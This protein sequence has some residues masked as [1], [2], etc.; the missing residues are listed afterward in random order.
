[1]TFRLVTWNI[2]S[3]R[4]RLHLLAQ[5]AEALDPDVI[6]LQEIKVEDAKFPGEAIAEIGYPHQA[7]FGMKAYHGVATLAKAPMGR[8]TRHSWCGKDDARHV[9]STVAGGVELHNLY[10]PAGG[11]VPDP[12]ANDKFAHKLNFFDEQTDWWAKQKGRAKRILVGDLNVAPL[13]TDVWNHKQL[14]KV[15]SHTPIEVEHYSRMEAA[16]KWIDA[17]RH[18]IPPEEHLYSWWSYRARDWRASNKGRRLDH[19]WVTPN[20]K[21]AIRD[22]FVYD[23]ARDWEK[24]S[25]HAPVVVDFDF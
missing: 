17:V 24:A 15:V 3:V 8:E 23:Q 21:G 4:A 7:V 14:L 10:I 19:V 9:A 12:A 11:D 6:C 20:L 13:E 1:M 22:A 25:D 2:N 16:H 5:L 18:V